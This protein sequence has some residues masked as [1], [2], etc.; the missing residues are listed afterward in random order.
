MIRWLLVLLVACFSATALATEAGES[1]PPTIQPKKIP[2]EELPDEIKEKIIEK[3]KESDQLS[4]DVKQKLI[5]ATEG[6]SGAEV[7]EEEPADEVAKEKEDEKDKK[8]EKEEKSS[9]NKRVKELKSQMEEM[10]AEFKFKIAQYKQE[11]EAERLKIAKAKLHR[12]IEDALGADADRATKKQVEEIKLQIQLIEAK[13]KL[14]AAKNTESLRSLHATKA[15]AEAELASRAATKKLDDI[16][17]DDLEYSSTPYAKGVLTISDRRIELNGP[18]MTGA[19]EYVAD[20]IQ[21]FNN[22]SKK[23]IFLIIDSSPGGSGMEGLHILQAMHQSEAPVHVVVKRFAASMAAIITTLADH[24]YAFPNAI[25]LHH[26]ASSGTQGNTTMQ[27]E[28]LER[29]REMS[30]RLVGEVAEKI[31][32]TEEQFIERMYK[33]RSSGDWDL[34]ADE[35]VKQGWVDHVV[36]N[37]R[38]TS[39]RKRPQGA[40]AMPFSFFSAD[41]KR[42]EAIGAG[43]DRYEVRLEEQ[44]DER[45][46]RFVRLPRLSPLDHWFLYS[47]DEYYR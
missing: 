14:A 15:A 20:R 31:G 39:V 10:E 34:F 45:G 22:E 12:G 17:M 29:L 24:S 3:I 32:I 35:A 26:Q 38:E 8:K 27:K 5:D 42:S 37:V 9:K 47:P 44:R 21:Y 2:F 28:H 1:N 33:N 18:I 19:A 23:P 36:D 6:K 25:I 16:V 40:R 4:D 13:A 11:M 46:K 30:A 41:Q 43:M 7:S